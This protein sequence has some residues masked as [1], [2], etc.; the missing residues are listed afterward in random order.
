MFIGD[1]VAED[2]DSYA[3]VVNNGERC[4]HESNEHS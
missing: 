3:R 2:L 1:G 4:I